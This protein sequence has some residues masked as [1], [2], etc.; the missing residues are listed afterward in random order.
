MISLIARLEQAQGGDRELDA[1]T[2]ETV[3]KIR[4]AFAD[5]PKCIAILRAHGGG[6][7]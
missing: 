5:C 2:R 3:R 7:E 6:N 1:T 4:A